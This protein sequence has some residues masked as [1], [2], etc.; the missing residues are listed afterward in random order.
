MTFPGLEAATT[1]YTVMSC[2]SITLHN[3]PFTFVGKETQGVSFYTFLK[4]LHFDFCFMKKSHKSP[5]TI[6]KMYVFKVMLVC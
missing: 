4:T 3:S 2:T 1:T 5:G 6:Q